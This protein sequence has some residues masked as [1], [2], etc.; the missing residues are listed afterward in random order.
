M[1]GNRLCPSLFASY[2]EPAAVT[3]IGFDCLTRYQKTAFGVCM[4]S[5]PR[6]GVTILRVNV[7]EGLLACESNILISNKGVERVEE[8]FTGSS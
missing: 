4:F 3:T 1:P 8:T 2:A 7:A 5:L 6:L